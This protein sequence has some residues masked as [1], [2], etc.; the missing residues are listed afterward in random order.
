MNIYSV[1]VNSSSK[2]HQEPIFIKQGFSF[3]AS[4]FNCLWSLYHRMWL[5][6]LITIAMS[7]LIHTVISHN[8][9]Y[10]LDIALLFIF[11]FFGAEM[12]EYDAKRKGYNL[13]DIV[14]AHDVEEA[15]IRYLGKIEQKKQG[16]T[17]QRNGEQDV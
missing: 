14:L 1:Y 6:T 9:I 10:L 3:W 5:V 13:D 11:G 8:Y 16:Q 4:F 15:E 7:F 2:N 12:R 17:R